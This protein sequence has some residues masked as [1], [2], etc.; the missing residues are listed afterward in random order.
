MNQ[1]NSIH[2]N[3]VERVVYTPKAM[4]LH[5]VTSKRKNHALTRD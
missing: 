5:G 2:A 4:A 3:D 1:W